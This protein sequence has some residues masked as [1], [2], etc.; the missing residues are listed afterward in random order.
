MFTLFILG[1]L[2]ILLYYVGAVPGGRSNYYLVLGLGLSWVVY[3]PPP[4]T[5]DLKFCLVQLL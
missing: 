5:I 3:L 4:N 2:I 1:A